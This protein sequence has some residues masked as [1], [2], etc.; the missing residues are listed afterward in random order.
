VADITRFPVIV[1]DN[2]VTNLVLGILSYLS[3]AATVPLALLLLV[4]TGQTPTA[5]GL[6]RPSWTQDVWPGLGLAAASFGA[7]IPLAVVI[8]PLVAHHS[9]LVNRVSVGHVPG[10]YVIWGIAMSAITA[11]AE[12]RSYSACAC[13]PATTSTTASGFSSPFLSATSSPAPSRST[14]GSTGR[15]PPTS[16]STPSSRPS[17]S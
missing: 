17:P 14:T 7:E 13:A 1:A 4:R 2:P 3:V 11:I 15:S 16:S 10:Y 8:S 9:D 5:L 6:G 12:E